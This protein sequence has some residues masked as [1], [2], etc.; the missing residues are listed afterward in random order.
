MYHSQSASVRGY[1]DPLK[2]DGAAYPHD[3]Q[4]NEEVSPQVTVFADVR[5]DLANLN[6]SSQPG[7]NQGSDGGSTR[8]PHNESFKPKV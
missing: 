4:V 5:V 3:S 6:S 2:R 8:T 7:P 1:A